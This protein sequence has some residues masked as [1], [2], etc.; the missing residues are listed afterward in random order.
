MICS[1]IR[2]SQSVVMVMCETPSSRA[3]ATLSE[4]MLNPRP[5]N[6]PATRESTPGSFSTSTESTC[7]CRAALPYTSSISS[8]A[9]PAGTMGYTFSS[10][11]TTTSMKAGLGEARAFSS[12]VTSSAGS[13]MR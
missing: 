2:L 1:R 13:T 10:R 3:G 6:S 11:S 4:W 12:T 9:A 5:L 7:R 8:S